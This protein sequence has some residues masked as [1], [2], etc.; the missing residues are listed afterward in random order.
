[1]KAL[2]ILVFIFIT[3]FSNAQILTY[4]NLKLGLNIDAYYAKSSIGKRISSFE[5][6]ENENIDS[7]L[8]AFNY[9]ARAQDLIRLYNASLTADYFNEDIKA[10]ATIQYGDINN[11]EYYGS[12]EYVREANVGFSP[13]KNLW[14]EGG[15][16][17]Q[18]FSAEPVLPGNNFLTSTAIQSGFEPR[19]LYMA[20]L[21]YEFIN[22]LSASFL[23]SEGYD[24]RDYV[25]KNKFFGLM[26]NYSPL[27]NLNIRFNNFTGN[28]Y[29]LYVESW[30]PYID[31]DTR[32]VLR[33]FNNLIVTYNLNDKLKFISGIDYI[34]QEKSNLYSF[35]KSTPVLTAFVS[36]RY[37]I[38]N[39]LSVSGRAEYVYDRHGIFTLAG[40]FR[41]YSLPTG[42][43]AGAFAVG[44]EYSPKEQLYARLEMNYI[45]DYQ[46]L[47]FISNITTLDN[48]DHYTMLTGIASIGLR[49]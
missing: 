48:R 11:Y 36:G 4:D 20:K 3:G 46:K 47:Q 31:L 13:V 1:M 7:Y 28:V 37:Q 18:P 30:D 21:T 29:G 44:I 45:Q 49:F 24:I 34:I 9:T 19:K 33:I 25:R 16:Y 38:N 42:M 35:T 17:F 39:K 27:N 22:N 2:F 32:T 26:L 43:E 8:Y 14:V 41:E 23:V 6:Y 15:I 40:Y 12:V 5:P 10:K